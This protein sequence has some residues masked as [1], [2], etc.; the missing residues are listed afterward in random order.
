M[1]KRSYIKR[2]L[3]EKRSMESENVPLEPY[4]G[5]PPL[6]IPTII[7]IGSIKYHRS[8]EMIFLLSFFLMRM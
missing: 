4:S 6:S 2:P 5:T 1:L 7:S 8:G 3:A